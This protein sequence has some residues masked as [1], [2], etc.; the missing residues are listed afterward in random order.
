MIT[1]PAI[2][3]ASVIQP[4]QG[5]IGSKDEVDIMSTV[6]SLE[7]TVGR[8][9][10]GDLSDLEGMLVAQATALQ[11]MFVNLAR[12]AQDQNYQRHLEAFMGLAFKAQAGSRATISALVDLKYPRTTVIARQANVNNGGQQQVNNAGSATSTRTGAGVIN[13]DV[14]ESTLLEHSHGQPCGWL[15]ARATS[16]AE[17]G[18][19]AMEAVGEVHRAQDGR[20]KGEGRA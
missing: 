19:P 4:Y 9:R 2:N 17:R 15:D 10:A 6:R 1:D 13:T 14:A 7:E 16:K 8:V 3:A 18:D 11:T 12:R 5:Y 20:G